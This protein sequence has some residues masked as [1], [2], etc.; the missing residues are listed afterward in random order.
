[1]FNLFILKKGN[2]MKN[3][4]LKS[5]VAFAFLAGVYNLDASHHVVSSERSA[6]GSST[7]YHSG[8]GSSQGSWTGS[9]SSQGASSETYTPGTSNSHHSKFNSDAH[10]KSDGSKKGANGK[11]KPKKKSSSEGH[12][13]SKKYTPTTSRSE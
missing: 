11:Y 7:G 1:L 12:K 6:T 8:S 13:S 2:Y 10:N 3:V 5:M 4:L 9:E